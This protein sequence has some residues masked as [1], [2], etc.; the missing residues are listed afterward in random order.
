MPRADRRDPHLESRWRD[1]LARW[2]R[3]GQTVRAFC[4]AQGL[5]EN[6]FYAWRRE[7]AARDRQAAAPPATFVPLRVAAPAVLEVVLTTGV[8]IRV[9]TGADLAT[10]ARLVAALGAQ[11]C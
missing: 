2:K 6:N 5:N 9:P 1:R 10:V 8:I 3:S 11:P 7:L 4:L